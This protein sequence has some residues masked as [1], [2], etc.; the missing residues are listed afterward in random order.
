M[1]DVGCSIF[2]HI[3]YYHEMNEVSAAIATWLEKKRRADRASAA[4]ISVLAL[5]SG[6]AVF[7]LMTLLIYIVLTIVIGVFNHSVPWLW[8]VALGLSAGIFVRSMRGW[9]ENPELSLDPM[10]YWIIKDIC[11]VGPRLILE[12]L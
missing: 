2:A 8:V 4:V 1:F 10:G 5:S 3:C 12:G 7:L 6:T 9:R 11:S